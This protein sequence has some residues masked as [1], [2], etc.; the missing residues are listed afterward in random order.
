MINVVY[1][2]GKH[3]KHYFEEVVHCLH[4]GRQNLESF[5]SVLERTIFEE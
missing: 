3:Y 4:G 1:G 2:D 5:V